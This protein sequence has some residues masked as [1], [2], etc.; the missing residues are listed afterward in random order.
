MV[1][2]KHDYMDARILFLKS[3]T[4][5]YQF[6]LCN[7]ANTT[8][9]NDKVIEI[10]NLIINNYPLKPV[11]AKQSYD[12]KLTF[13][14]ETLSAVVDFLDGK[15]MD[16]LKLYNTRDYAKVESYVFDIFIIKPS[17]KYFNGNLFLKY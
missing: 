3:R 17:E 10:I 9:S 16:V 6:G 15:I 5:R 12:G 8:L 14:S 4:D 13:Y 2:L 1:D 7:I 11:Y